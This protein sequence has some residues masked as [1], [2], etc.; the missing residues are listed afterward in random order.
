MKKNYPK[1]MAF[2]M[3]IFYL[4]AFTLLPMVPY[5]N[6]R[7][8]NEH[9]FVKWILFGDIIATAKSLIWPYF[10]F[11]GRYRS[12]AISSDEKHYTNSKIACDEAMKIIIKA[13]DVSQLA[14]ADRQ[15]VV[16]LLEIA[17]AEADKIKP[18]YLQKVH[19]QF[20]EMYEKNYKKGIQ[21]LI[22]GFK[23]DDTSSVLEGGCGYNEYAEWMQ[24]N[25]KDLKF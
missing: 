11:F 1:V 24:L 3:I 12:S 16:N 4:Y 10:I 14:S 13:G 23:T 22:N 20:S 6:W 7:Y 8:A 21:L 17:Y 2:G 5:F 19:P 15:K 25:K 9:G 18:E